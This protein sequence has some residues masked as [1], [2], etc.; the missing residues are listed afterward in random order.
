MAVRECLY[1][2]EGEPP[3]ASLSLHGKKC[4]DDHLLLD[5]DESRLA[6]NFGFGSL[7]LTQRLM[8]MMG[9]WD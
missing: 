9:V 8:N 4:G 1:S 6:S 2:C 5:D 3:C 7:F